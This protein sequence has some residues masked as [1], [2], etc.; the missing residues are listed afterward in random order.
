VRTIY[1]ISIIS[2]S[3]GTI[4]LPTNPERI[5]ISVPGDDAG[6]NLLQVGAVVIP[7]KRRLKTM[8]FAAFFTAA[9]DPGTKLAQIDQIMLQKEVIR[10]FLIRK[11]PCG[12]SLW[13]SNFSC[14][15]KNFNY[16]EQGGEVGTV[17]FDIEFTEHRAF[18]VRVLK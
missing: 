10:V 7:R 15:I 4:D 13:D 1:K 6:Y 8:S 5:T 12:K 2:P 9:D 11:D 17:F 3:Q 14:I 18:Y 16:Y